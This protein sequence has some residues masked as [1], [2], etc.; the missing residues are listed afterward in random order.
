MAI[1]QGRCLTDLLDKGW[2]LLEPF[3]HS[4]KQVDVNRSSETREIA[5]AI[6][7][8]LYVDVLANIVL[9]CFKHDTSYTSTF[10]TENMVVF[11]RK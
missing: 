3:C 2:V 9:E 5:D 4:P 8:F 11:G 1:S 10:A 6:L 7:C